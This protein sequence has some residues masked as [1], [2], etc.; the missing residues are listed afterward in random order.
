MQDLEDVE[1]AVFDREEHAM[2]D[3]GAGRKDAAHLREL[4]H[5]APRVRL[6]RGE[7][8]DDAE[9]AVGGV[10]RELGDGL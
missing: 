8:G 1:R 9:D 4:L 7:R 5:A 3:P 2:M 6:P 10:G